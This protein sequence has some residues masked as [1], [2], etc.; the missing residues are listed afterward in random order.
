MDALLIV[1]FNSHFTHFLTRA[2]IF[3]KPFTRWI[4]TTLNMVPIYRIRDGWQSLSEN[5]KTFEACYQI[6]TKNEAVVIFPEGNHGGQRRLRP[7]SKGFARIAFE[8]LQKNPELKISIVPVGLNYSDH[9]A[10][11]GSVSI[12]FGKPILANDYFKENLPSGAGQLRDDLSFQLKQ[13]ITHVENADEYNS[14]IQK[15]ENSTPDFLDPV[16][17]NL[18]ISKIENGEEL[19]TGSPLIKKN[20]SPGLLHYLAL[21]IN[22]IPLM[23]W[24]KINNEIKDP[25]FT[26]SLK[27]GVGIF[28]FP[29]FYLLISQ[30]VYSIWGAVAAFGWVVI[31]FPSMLFYRK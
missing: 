13:L 2:D 19:P 25:V 6:F 1:C 5:L 10:F 28:V 27:F 20:Y 8:A 9:K 22:F 17:T 23:L 4:L 7:L 16:K 18:A 3:K 12:Y 29:F 21:L 11:R 26:T 15:L 14:I 24:K 30:I 31:S